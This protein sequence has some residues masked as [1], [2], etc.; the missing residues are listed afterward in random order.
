MTSVVKDR[1]ERVAMIMSEHCRCNGWEGFG[2]CLHGMKECPF[3][4]DCMD[5]TIDMWL[6]YL[7][8]GG[9]YKIKQEKPQCL[10][11]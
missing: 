7:T 2:D 4:A 1:L 11:P 9:D 6:R 8:E 10:K 3:E 5:V